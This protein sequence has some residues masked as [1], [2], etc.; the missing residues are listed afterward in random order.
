MDGVVRSPSLFSMTFGL[1]PSMTA[2]HEFV[3]PKSMPITRPMSQCS[4]LIAFRRAPAHSL[5]RSSSPP[6]GFDPAGPCRPK[7]GMEGIIQGGAPLTALRNEHAGRAQHPVVHL[8]ALLDDLGD[9]A[10]L[11]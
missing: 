8:V 3:V 1:P 7:W 11:E 5:S 4:K 6:P 2:T 9:A 10:R